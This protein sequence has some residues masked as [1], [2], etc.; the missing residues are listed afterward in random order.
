MNSLF[1]QRNT[2]AAWKSKEYSFSKVI[3]ESY[4]VKKSLFPTFNLRITLFRHMPSL[5]Y[6]KQIRQ[7]SNPVQSHNSLTISSLMVI[8]LVESPEA[9]QLLIF[10]DMAIFIAQLKTSRFI[11]KTLSVSIV[12]L[13]P[14]RFYS[15]ISIFPSEFTVVHL[16]PLPSTIV[17]YVLPKLYFSILSL[18]SASF[19]VLTCLAIHRSFI[20]I[21]SLSL[22]V[23]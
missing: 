17:Q 3:F 8:N 11:V 9:Y 12:S 18:W 14:Y 21:I 1:C 15:F 13:D 23:A 6:L 7:A 19:I 20:L 5:L 4:T 2:E 22:I 16:L 10:V